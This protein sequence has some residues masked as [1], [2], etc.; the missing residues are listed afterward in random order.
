MFGIP[1]DDTP[2]IEDAQ[3]KDET[4][5]IEIPAL[6]FSKSSTANQQLARVMNTW[7]KRCFSA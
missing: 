2:E 5:C 6:P 1:T 7:M 3:D 4:G